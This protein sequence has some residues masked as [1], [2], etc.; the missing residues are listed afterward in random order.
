MFV[1]AYFEKVLLLAALGVFEFA[2]FMCL[3]VFSLSPRS[4]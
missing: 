2:K 1:V 4:G 3:T